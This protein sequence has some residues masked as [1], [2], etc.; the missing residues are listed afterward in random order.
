M[1]TVSSLA[2][3]SPMA[4]NT[5]ETTLSA[6]ALE[7]ETWAATCV[8]S[9]DLFMRRFPGVAFER[10]RSMRRPLSVPRRSAARKRAA[11]PRSGWQLRQARPELFCHR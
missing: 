6:S 11:R 10:P 7:T 5:A 3:A 4:E 1:A 2:S 8:L 9:S